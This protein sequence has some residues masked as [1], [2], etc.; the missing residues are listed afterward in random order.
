MSFCKERWTADQGGE[1]LDTY[2][3]KKLPAY[4]RSAVQKLIAEGRI[5][6]N[7]AP[8]KPGYR[9]ESGDE[10][11][12]SLTAPES[13]YLQAETIPLD[14]VYE[15]QDLLVVN[16]QAG[17]VVHPGAGHSH[18]T[19]VNA[20][21]AQVPDLPEQ[22]TDR[23]GIVHRLDRDTSGLIAI[24]KNDQAIEQLQAQFRERRVEKSYLALVEGRLQP[25]QGIVDAPIGRDP[26]QRQRMAVVSDGRPARTAYQ[27]REHL[28]AYTYLEARPETGRTHQIRVH[29]AAIG[30]PIYGD[31][32]YGR[33]KSS[34]GR[35]FLHA[36][37]LTLD[38]PGSG[39][40]RTFVAPLPNDLQTILDSLR[41]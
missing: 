12:L 29:L 20:L 24:A 6:V 4:S 37:Q 28:G 7:L 16:K 34:E 32:I 11:E 2:V 35:L 36:W 22:D 18:G 19:L 21:L 3:V 17:L 40:R 8:A 41:K 25:N 23:P 9:L 27:V 39:E 31:P 5:C 13:E 38:L 33:H 1:R 26:R 15:D 14:I 10:I 30:H